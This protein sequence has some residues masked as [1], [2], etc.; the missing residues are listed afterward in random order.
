MVRSLG[1]YA[2]VEVY[3]VRRVR[4]NNLQS[5]TAAHLNKRGEPAI[6]INIA[7]IDVYEAGDHAGLTEAMPMPRIR[8]LP[9][10][11]PR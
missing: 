4:R 7:C 10:M 11:L 5:C 2:E 3:S 1:V 6:L 8:L 9:A